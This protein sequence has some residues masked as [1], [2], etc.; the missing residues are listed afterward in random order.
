MKILVTIPDGDIKDTFYTEKSK[1]AVESLGEVIYNPLGR[2]YTPEELR[3]ALVGIDVCITSWETP[4]LTEEVLSRADKL[5]IVAHGAGSVA[6]YVS[7]AVFDKNIHVLTGNPVFAESVAEGC[8]AYIM[9]SYRNLERHIMQMRCGAWKEPNPKNRGIMDRSIGLVGFGLIAKNFVRM[10]APFHMDI[11]IYSSHMSEEE[12]RSYGATKASLDEIFSTCDIIS[13]HAAASP[14]RYHMIKYE[15]FSKMKDGA[16][17][18]NTARSSLIDQDALEKVMETGRVSAVLDVF[19]GEPPAPDWKM[20]SMPNVILLP[21]MGG[22]T[23]DRREAVILEVVRD[24][25]C[26]W[27]GRIEDVTEGGYITREGARRMSIG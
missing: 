26:V 17:F 2:Q 11:K 8:I 23:I 27:E 15:H 9:C 19:E 3:D 16:L 5:K 24:I 14:E 7:E 13:M 1:A 20:R 12:A 21:H 18:I 6:P 22:P 25:K 4:K 10:L